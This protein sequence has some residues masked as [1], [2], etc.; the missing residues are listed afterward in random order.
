MPINLDINLDKMFRKTKGVIEF[1][2]TDI[3][4]KP[5][6]FTV[7]VEIKDT[8]EQRRFGYPKN[9]GWEREIDGEEKFIHDIRNKLF[10]EALGQSQTEAMDKIRTKLK[11]KVLK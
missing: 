5:L 11:R 10:D 1:E 9:C 8:K 7:Q 6:G 2:I 3:V 4:E